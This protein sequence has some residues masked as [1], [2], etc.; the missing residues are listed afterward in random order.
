MAPLSR[1][2]LR[3]QFGSSLSF[4]AQNSS[5]QEQY[6]KQPPLLPILFPL[7]TLHAPQ[8]NYKPNPVDDATWSSLSSQADFTSSKL[9][10]SFL[11]TSQHFSHLHETPWR[12]CIQRWCNG[13]LLGLRGGRERV[14]K[15]F[16]QQETIY[17]FYV[18]TRR[19]LL[20]QLIINLGAGERSPSIYN[21]PY[22][23]YSPTGLA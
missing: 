11:F 21:R 16:Q 10:R 4:L 23:L 20:S 12:A 15:L 1:N 17:A 13:R 2:I 7:N 8:I 9:H 14:G 6:L 19:G 22:L 5:T 18:H 3:L